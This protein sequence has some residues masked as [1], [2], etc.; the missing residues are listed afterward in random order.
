MSM[1]ERV[2]DLGGGDYGMENARKDLLGTD[3]M[4]DRWDVNWM[5]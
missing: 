3:V 2:P 1:I 4:D 5:G